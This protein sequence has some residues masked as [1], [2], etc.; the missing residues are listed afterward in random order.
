MNTSDAAYHL[1]HDYKGGSESLAPRMGISAAL[2]RNKV[3]RNRTPENRNVLSLAEAVNM[4][5]LTGDERILH[6]WASERN[7]V[8]VRLPEPTEQPDNEE[9]LGLFMRLTTEFGALAQRHQEATED[10]E[11]DEQEKSDL[12]RLGNQIHQTVQQ[13]QS[14]TEVIYCRPST[15]S[16]T[17]PQRAPSVRVV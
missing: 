10:G 6:A 8:L 11:V 17:T 13:I 15:G 5:D 4:T 12:K 7:S 14:L 3:N 9:L 16:G 2:L 1:V